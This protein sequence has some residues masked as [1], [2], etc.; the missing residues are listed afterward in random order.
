MVRSIL[1]SVLPRP[2]TM[3]HDLHVTLQCEV[4]HAQFSVS[5]RVRFCAKGCN[6]ST[7][8]PFNRST[9]IYSPPLADSATALAV[10][11]DNV[12]E[13]PTT[14]Y[15]S[16]DDAVPGVQIGILPYQRAIMLLELSRALVEHQRRRLQ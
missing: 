1:L 4:K 12:L 16:T 14:L 11:T 8:S 15:M 2:L 6:Q 13:T 5:P 10:N 9:D 7:P 3:T